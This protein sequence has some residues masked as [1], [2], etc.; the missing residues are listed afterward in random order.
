MNQSLLSYGVGAL[1]YCPADSKNIVSSLTEERFGACFSLAL[2]LEDTIKDTCVASA[3]ITLKESFRRLWEQKDRLS[4]FLPQIFIRVRTPEQIER[5]VRDLGETA[6]ILTGFI[7]PKVSPENLPAFLDALARVNAERHAGLYAMPILENPAMFPPASRMDFL[8]RIKKEL[9][10]VPDRILNIRVGGNDLCHAFGLRRH[11][12]DTIYDILPVAGL[13]SD[14]LTVFSEDYVLSAPVWEYYGG[15]HWETGMQRELK[16]DLLNGFIG[17]TVIHPK[18]IPVVNGMLA[19]S[20]E[21]YSDACAIVDWDP[22][23]KRLVSAGVSKNR[24]NEQK[25]HTRWA[26]KTLLLAHLYGIRRSP[27]HPPDSE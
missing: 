8:Y 3:E 17:K 16:K 23:S 7:F 13:L 22:L 2:C 19:V 10:A 12:D 26:E 1:L 6:A 25:T 15:S 14:I 21:D 4:F 24:M 9:D 27:T 5:L 11:T 18:Q 20:P